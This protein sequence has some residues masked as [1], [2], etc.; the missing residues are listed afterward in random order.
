MSGLSIFFAATVKISA[1]L[2][3]HLLYF[4]I[5]SRVNFDPCPAPVV[6]W[7]DYEQDEPDL[8]Q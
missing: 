4:P 7:A 5:L 6:T 2:D 8:T 3:R 1:K